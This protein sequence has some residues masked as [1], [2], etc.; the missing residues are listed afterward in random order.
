MNICSLR[1]LTLD[2]KLY[3]FTVADIPVAVGEDT[4]VLLKRRFSP[5][6][7][8]NTIVIGSDVGVYVGDILKGDDELWYVCYE[9]GFAA[10][11]KGREKKRLLYEF[12][13]LD[14]VGQMT[15]EEKVEMGFKKL[16]LKF[17]Y[18][19]YIFT[20]MDIVGRYKDDLVLRNIQGRVM[21]SDIQQDLITSI[22]GKKVYLG[23]LYRGLPIFMCWGRI[24]IQTEFGVYDILEKGYIQQYERRLN[25]ES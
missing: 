21:S 8:L 12:D 9:S 13:T 6:L 17:K 5:I 14:V 3:A 11:T 23:D 24:C 15:E 19:G 22:G 1:A 10:Y 16:K 18:N 7:Q 4:F 25:D 20:Q 2:N